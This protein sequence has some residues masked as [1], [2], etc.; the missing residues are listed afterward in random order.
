MVYPESE[1]RPTRRVAQVT[2]VGQ[3]GEPRTR[4]FV[5]A[6]TIPYAPGDLL[7]AERVGEGITGVTGVAWMDRNNDGRTWAEGAVLDSGS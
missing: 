5:E 6:I 7:I 1:A 2:D 4:S 3:N